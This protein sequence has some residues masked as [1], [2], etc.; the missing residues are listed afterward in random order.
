RRDDAGGGAFAPRSTRR[1]VRRWRG[2]RRSLADSGQ[3]SVTTIVGGDAPG[4]A[5]AL[6]AGRRAQAPW[7]EAS[8]G[9]SRNLISPPTV[10]WRCRGCRSGRSSCTWYWLR[11][12]TRVFVREPL[13]FRS[14]TIWA[15]A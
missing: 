11:R 14:A 2:T 6:T 13:F 10:W 3:P 12:P 8:V 7:A 1:P 4:A 9:S 5:H 15:A